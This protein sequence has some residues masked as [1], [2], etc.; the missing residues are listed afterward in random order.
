MHSR[1]QQ[2]FVALSYSRIDWSLQLLALCSYHPS[3]QSSCLRSRSAHLFSE[4]LQQQPA[5]KRLTAPGL[6]S[7]PIQTSAICAQ[8]SRSSSSLMTECP[9]ATSIE[10]RFLAALTACSQLTAMFSALQPSWCLRASRAQEDVNWIS[11]FYL[12]CLSSARR[13]RFSIRVGFYPKATRRWF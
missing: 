3:F 10:C 8:W 2:Y 1:H 12:Y 9:S 7:K 13:H 6:L 5:P 4:P 11:K